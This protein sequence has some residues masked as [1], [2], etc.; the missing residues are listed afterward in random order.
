MGAVG[1]GEIFIM[2]ENKTNVDIL[3]GEE[4][5]MSHD[6]HEL[7]KKLPNPITQTEIDLAIKEGRFREVGRMIFK[8]YVVGCSGSVHL[9]ENQILY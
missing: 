1:Y 2:N 4:C 3:F 7:N 9:S 5:K 8:L 6:Y